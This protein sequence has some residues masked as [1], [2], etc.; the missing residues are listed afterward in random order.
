SL[1]IKVGPLNTL[2]RSTYY[3][4]SLISNK[5]I[6]CYGQR[7]VNF[8]EEAEQPWN[9]KNQLW[10]TSSNPSVTA[11]TASYGSSMFR[12]P[13]MSETS[14]SKPDQGTEKKKLSTQKKQKYAYIPDNFS[15]LEQ[16]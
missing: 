5:N 12:K 15:T 16:L 8:Q 7:H 4:P 3:A 1:K 9:S 11:R 14:S 13:S 6:R 10:W 2:G